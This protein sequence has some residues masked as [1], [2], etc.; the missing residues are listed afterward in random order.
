MCSGEF[1]NIYIYIALRQYI[2][3]YCLNAT[4]PPGHHHNV[5]VLASAL[6]LIHAQLCVILVVT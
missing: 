4:C 1:A 3:I 5:F 6:G 2:Y